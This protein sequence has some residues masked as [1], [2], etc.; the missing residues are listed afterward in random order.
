MGTV[1]HDVKI[2]VWGGFGDGKFGVL[3]VVDGI[4]EQ[5]QYRDILTEGTIASV[6]ISRYCTC[7]IIPS[8]TYKTLTLTPD[9]DLDIMLH[10]AHAP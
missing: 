8:T 9:V 1:K 10:G 6:R 4:M 2:N 3:H 7:S 5:V